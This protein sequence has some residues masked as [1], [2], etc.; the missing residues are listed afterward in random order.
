MCLELLHWQAG[1]FTLGATWEGTRKKTRGKKAVSY[2]TILR[3]NG[4]EN[5]GR[6]NWI[7]ENQEEMI[8]VLDNFGGTVK[9]IECL[10]STNRKKTIKTL[11]GKKM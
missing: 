11:E 2:K 10:V 6:K 7:L 1:F 3:T 4:M 5:F 9:K 8:K